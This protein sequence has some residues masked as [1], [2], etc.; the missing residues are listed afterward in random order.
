MDSIGIESAAVSDCFERFQNAIPSQLKPQ[1][2][3]E[4]ESKG[5]ARW[6]DVEA[7]RGTTRGR[8]QFTLNCQVITVILYC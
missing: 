4:L 3:P 6:Y 8:G 7:Q 5:F 1:G 2:D